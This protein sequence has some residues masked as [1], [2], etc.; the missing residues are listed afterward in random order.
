ML[1]AQETASERGGTV[2]AAIRFL[3]MFLQIAILGGGALLVIDGLTGPGVMFGSMMLMGKALAPVERAVGSWQ[4]IIQTRQAFSR[5]NA[6]TISE[7][8]LPAFH[9]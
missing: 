5:L 2:S 4:A 6:L 9:I 1:Q 3:R 8:N 7:P